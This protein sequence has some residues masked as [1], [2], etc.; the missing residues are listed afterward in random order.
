MP[1]ARDWDSRGFTDLLNY[2]GPESQHRCHSS[3]LFG[4]QARGVLRPTCLLVHACQ[5]CQPYCLNL[6][7]ICSWSCCIA[8][9]CS[10]A[11]C[12]LG[13]SHSCRQHAS[14]CLAFQHTEHA[15]V[16]KQCSHDASNKPITSVRQPCHSK[17]WSRKMQQGAVV[18]DRPTELQQ[19][20]R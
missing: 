14:V 19:Q 13:C 18:Q 3:S 4:S 8:I 1:E 5:C 2:G 15:L 9:G 17:F 10:T 16:Y 7:S 6:S 20:S 12:R 11:V